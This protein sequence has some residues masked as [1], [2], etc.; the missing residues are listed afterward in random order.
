MSAVFFF[1][2]KVER[3]ISCR[4]L[5]PSMWILRATRVL[6][7]AHFPQGCVPLPRSP[8]NTCR[9]LTAV[10]PR[11]GE[12]RHAFART[13]DIDYLIA[14]FQPSHQNCKPKV[15]AANAIETELLHVDFI[16]LYKGIS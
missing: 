7:R 1:G 13:V 10:A 12:P 2:Q 9:G 15:F 4:L 5:G 16:V 14:I 11:L 8:Q 6:F 3:P